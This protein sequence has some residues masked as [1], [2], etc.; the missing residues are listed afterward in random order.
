MIVVK[1]LPRNTVLTV[2]SKVYEP[3][4]LWRIPNLNPG[5]Y[6]LEVSKPSYNPWSHTV[7]IEAGQTAI[8]EDVVLFLLKPTETPIENNT[9]KAK[10]ISDLNNQRTDTSVVVEDNEITFDGELV[11]RYSKDIFNAKLYADEAHIT[12]IADNQFHVIDLD[13]S[14]DLALFSLKN[15]SKYLLLNGGQTVLCLEGDK[16]RQV[17]IR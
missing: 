10:L 8:F 7:K 12:F 5:E 16:L 11:T 17:R 13:G 15:D 1:A 2:N 3:D 9:E 4:N 6:S 14:N